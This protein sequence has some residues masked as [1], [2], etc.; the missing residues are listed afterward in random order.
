M[1]IIESILTKNPCYTAGRKIDVKGLMLHS[2]GCPQPSA[3]AFVDS[4]NKS[5][6]SSACVHAFIDATTGDVY[7]TLPWNHRG[8]HCGRSGN[9]THIGVEMC[10]PSCIKY[11]GGS[12]FTCS[13]YKKAQECA[14]RTYESAVELFAMLCEKFNLDPMKD[15]VSHSEGYKKGIA[16]NHSDPEHLWKGLGLTY[17][18]DTF[19]TSV[20]GKMKVSGGSVEVPSPVKTA[21]LQAT[22]LEDLTT[23]ELIQKVGSLFTADQKKTGV[24]ASVSFAQFI[25]ESGWGKSELA[26]KANNCFGMKKSLSGNTW[27]GST[28]NGA[29]YTKQTKEWNGSSYVTKTAEFRVYDC[30]EDSIEDHS[31]YLLGAMKG[32]EHR[33]EGLKGERDYRKAIT[34]IKNGGYATSPTYIDRICELIEQYGLTKYDLQEEVPEPTPA[35]VIPE[36]DEP[37][38]EIRIFYPSWTRES[39]PDDRRGAGC[40]WSDQNGKTL[41]IDNYCRN[42]VPANTVVDYLIK[43]GLTTVDFVGTHAHYDHISGGI[44]LLDDSRITVENVYCYDPETLKLAGSG[45]ANARSANE[46]KEYLKAFIRKAKDKG[47]KVHLVDDGDKI[48]CGEMRFDVF[49]IQP[50]KFTSLDQGQAYAY[51]NDGSLCLYS[52]QVYYMMV[53]DANGAESVDDYNL[54]VKGCEVGHHGNNGT[55][56]EAKIYISHGC[57]FAIQCNNEKGEAG[58]CEFT[59]Y[60]S[61]RMKEQG[62]TP[63]QLDA[64]IY[65]IIKGGQAVFTQGNRTKVWD[66]PFGKG[67]GVN[68]AVPHYF[69]VRKSWSDQDSQVGAYSIEKNAVLKADEMGSDY[70]VFDWTGKEIYRPKKKESDPVVK[71]AVPFLVKVSKSINIRKGASLNYPATRMCPVGIYTIV[72]ISTDGEWGKL[73]SGAGWI[74]LKDPSCSFLKS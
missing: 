2:V 44:Q 47:A 45:S 27:S 68:E 14:K 71:P 61:G 67:E 8:W 53:G 29:V 19:R 6:Y 11:T 17:T 37:D 43:S 54:I 60:G 28:W 20:K 63:W 58:S 39:S 21:G 5:S 32:S 26:V 16:T 12:S 42:S 62:V 46:D 66:C 51:I 22:E 74:W 34:I 33:Y 48:T 55:R 30:I 25:L 35:P 49:R 41:V 9:D 65:A 50:T 3:M 64:N 70:A 56:S 40:V 1:K 13:D 38:K 72:Q 4:W 73:K 36:P 69:R 7:Q 10:E 31:A 18:M 15:I 24:L 57:V 59:R 52:E 23:D